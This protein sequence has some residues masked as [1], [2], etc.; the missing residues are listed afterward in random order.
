[1]NPKLPQQFSMIKERERNFVCS[2]VKPIINREGVTGGSN[3]LPNQLSGSS[4]EVGEGVYMQ[5]YRKQH[6]H[7]SVL[8]KC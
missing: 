8:M 7:I 4:K 2:T 1:M 3:K 5:A 6:L